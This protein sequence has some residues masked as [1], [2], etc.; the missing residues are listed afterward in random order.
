[1]ITTRR[2][3]GTN[4]IYS[5]ESSASV[6]LLEKEEAK[7][8]NAEIK[9]ETLEEAKERMQRNL[10]KLLNYDRSAEKTEVKEQEV[11]LNVTVSD[12]E[13]DLKPSSTTMQFIEQDNLKAAENMKKASSVIA[14]QRSQVNSGKRFLMVLYS[15]AITVIL[16]L[17]VL[18]TGLLASLNKNSV[19]K[20]A[21]LNGVIT[22]YNQKLS[23]I[24][25]VTNND[26]V[27]EWAEQNGMSKR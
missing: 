9:E 3:D 7:D 13:E 16:A 17:I 2:L 18:N 11:A 6:A 23:D 22:E 10:D 15:L 25:S 12:N 1:M 20:Q 19:A 8:Y 24:D 14:T 26:Y 4:S 27:V 5:K 21:E